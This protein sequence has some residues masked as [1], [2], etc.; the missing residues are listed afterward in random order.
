[1]AVF[2]DLD[3]RSGFMGVVLDDRFV[4]QLTHKRRGK[5][6]VELLDTSVPALDACDVD[7]G[8]AESL[9]QAA[10]E[11]RDVFQVARASSCDWKHL[12]M[13]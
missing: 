9:I 5:V 12:D 8:F 11:S 3:P 10:A 2:R 7:F 4:L 6:G 13:V 1:M